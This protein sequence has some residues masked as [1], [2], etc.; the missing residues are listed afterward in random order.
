LSAVAVN[1]GILSGCYVRPDCDNREFDWQPR[2]LA[3]F[4]RQAIP[5]RDGMVGSI[6]IIPRQ[7]PE[8]GET[9][10]GPA[11]CMQDRRG[12]L[13]S[14]NNGHSRQAV[15]AAHA[16]GKVADVALILLRS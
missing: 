3:A 8:P 2:V 10:A 13:Q 1:P 4:L 6:F 15:V 5:D 11:C 16:A 12:H 7:T 9:L 14:C